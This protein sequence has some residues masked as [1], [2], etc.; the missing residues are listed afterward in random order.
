MQQFFAT[1]DERRLPTLLDESYEE[2]SL[3][4]YSRQYSVVG[5]PVHPYFVEQ[6]LALGGPSSS[7]RLRLCRYE[8]RGLS[9]FQRF[10]KWLLFRLLGLYFCP[11]ISA[12]II[13]RVPYTSEVAA[14]DVWW[15]LT[16]PLL[17]SEIYTVRSNVISRVASMFGYY[18]C[19]RTDIILP[20]RAISVRLHWALR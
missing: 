11:R 14:L 17:Q 10:V 3:Y 13:S 2:D 7:E 1:L 16:V 9:L 4:P 8:T 15:A 6:A 12:R 20:R 19:S 5:S 18:Y